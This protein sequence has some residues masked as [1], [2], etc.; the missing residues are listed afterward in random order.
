M[1]HPVYGGPNLYGNDLSHPATKLLG[2]DSRNEQDTH[3]HHPGAPN[4]E[5]RFSQPGLNIRRGKPVDMSQHTWQTEQLRQN[6]NRF[7]VTGTNVCDPR[8]VR[9]DSPDSPVSPTSFRGDELPLDAGE[10]RLSKLVNTGGICLR[11]K[12]YNEWPKQPSAWDIWRP[13]ED[14]PATPRTQELIDENTKLRWDVADADASFAE[15]ESSWQEKR[16]EFA[17]MMAKAEADREA[18]KVQLLTMCYP[19]EEWAQ[20]QRAVLICFTEWKSFRYTNYSKA[21]IGK[22]AQ[23]SLLPQL[24][25][26]KKI[27]WMGWKTFRHERQIMKAFDMVCD[28]PKNS[29]NSSGSKWI[30]E[31]M[32]TLFRLWRIE[33]MGVVFERQKIYCNGNMMHHAKSWFRMMR[34]EAHRKR[35]ART[36]ADRQGHA[37]NERLLERVFEIWKRWEANGFLDVCDLKSYSLHSTTHRCFSMWAVWTWSA[38]RTPEWSE[39]LIALQHEIPKVRQEW[40]IKVQR[41]EDKLEAIRRDGHLFTDLDLPLPGAELERLDELA[42]RRTYARERKRAGELKTM[43]QK[44]AQPPPSPKRVSLER[45]EPLSP[46]GR[47]TQRE[48]ER[49]PPPEPVSRKNTLGGLPSRKTVP[50]LRRLLHDMTLLEEV[51]GQEEQMH[52]EARMYHDKLGFSSVASEDYSDLGIPSDAHE[53]KPPGKYPYPRLE[54][55]PSAS[56]FMGTVKSGSARYTKRGSGTG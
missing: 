47:R 46:K 41:L 3:G 44:A 23:C 33:T 8:L 53:R 15:M 38:N 11:G 35:C 18:E 56:P 4:L 6:V 9:S 25:M 34:T 2:S 52:E 39:E 36:M 26:L 14:R 28:D 40:E 32:H 55:V 10:R 17:G 24:D 30:E 29:C 22:I 31:L 48:Q 43:I 54:S 45:R 1:A 13:V 37:R 7:S 20:K 50:N 5:G 12:M 49:P 21:L 16:D 42:I 51:M 27:T 19:N